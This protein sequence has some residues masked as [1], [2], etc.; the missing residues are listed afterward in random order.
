MDLSSARHAFV[1]GGASAIGVAIADAL[2]ARGVCVTAADIDKEA[3]AAASAQRGL[4]FAGI[5]LDVRDR[6]GWNAVKQKAEARFGPVNILVNN[7]GIGPNGHALA[8]MNPETFAGDLR[9][10]GK[11]HIVN[12]SSI[13]GGLAVGRSNCGASAVANFG[14]V[15]LSE[16]LREEL[17]SHG[18]GVSVLCP[19][20]MSTN[21]GLTTSRVG[22]EVL[23][24][25]E[26][27]PGSDLSPA[28]VADSVIDGI[29]NN[30]PYITS[31]PGCA[32]IIEERFARIRRA[33]Q[34]PPPN[35]ASKMLDTGKYRHAFVTGGASGIGL[36]VV[37]ALL[38]QGL[39]VSVADIDEEALA[40]MAQRGS[41][42]ATIALDV[43]DRNGWR[44]A[45]KLA[46]LRFGPVDILVNNAGIGTD[47]RH[48]AD[49]EPSSFDRMLAIDLV[50]VFNGVST[51]ATD[52]RAR[53]TGQIVNT[54]SMMALAPAYAG[55]GAYTA[56]KCGVVA[57]SE[58]LRSEMALHGVGVSVLCP[59]YVESSLRANT[60]K[61][62]S[63]V[64][65]SIVSGRVGLPLPVVGAYVVRGICE[66]HPYIVT[67]PETLPSFDQRANRILAAAAKPA[68]KPKIAP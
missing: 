15:G 64:S 23:D 36:G 59:A 35:P 46:E 6:S 47:G 7:A 21:L 10:R 40:R 13:A 33:F 55:T 4:R 30:E 68:K 45:K 39:A 67:H 19:G 37:D 58:V 26:L 8:D 61:A 62:G 41:N 34:I 49:A 11:C 32:P 2:L 27:M 42:V 54:S 16:V 48:C 66:N 57:L 31:H 65:P 9:A 5:A 14:I 17:A 53:K 18:V 3:L 52:L 63:D 29:V 25:E 22:G 24:L 60:I 20:L 38:G 44:T 28:M 56:A 43:R 1:T 51:F 12:T 50:G